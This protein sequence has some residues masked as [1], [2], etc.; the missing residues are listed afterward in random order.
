M[1]YPLAKSRPPPSLCPAAGY[2]HQ[3]SPINRESMIPR[4]ELRR[5]IDECAPRRLA[6]KTAGNQPDDVPGKERADFWFFRWGGSHFQA[7]PS[8]FWNAY[9][10]IKKY[11]QTTNTGHAGVRAGLVSTGYGLFFS[12]IEKIAQQQNHRLPPPC[13]RSFR[14]ARTSIK[15][16]L[17]QP[18]KSCCP[19][20]KTKSNSHQHRC[21]VKG[22]G[23]S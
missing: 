14:T 11:S 17:S 6:T 22:T 3:N 18:A 7:L 1:F 21:L 19:Q 9:P 8:F 2:R 12:L 23:K 20:M 5:A 10:S 16:L 4:Y 13:E 15:P